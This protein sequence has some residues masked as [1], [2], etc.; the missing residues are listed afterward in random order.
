MLPSSLSMSV[1]R[2]DPRTLPVQIADRIRA[3][4]SGGQIAADA[5]LPS[6]RA[7]SAEVGVARAVVESAYDQLTAEGWLHARHGSGTFVRRLPTDGQAANPTGSRRS[8]TPVTPSVQGRRI[9]L[10]TGTP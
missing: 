10:A 4:I 2:S 1:D 3:A 9:R 5:R 8:T 7:L 6:S